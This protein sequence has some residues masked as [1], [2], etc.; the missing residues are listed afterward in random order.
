[1]LY[2][3]PKQTIDPTSQLTF[4]RKNLQKL[5]REI[6]DLKG[7]KLLYY[8]NEQTMKIT[9]ARITEMPKG[10]FDPMPKVFVRVNEGEEQLL[11]EF[12]PDEIMFTSKEFIGLT[13]EE[14]RHLKFLKDKKYL[15]DEK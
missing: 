3:I 2:C 13:I 9:S 15:Q 4:S 12:Y 5:F 1:L 11:F 6:F 14:A 7:I 8:I 10:L